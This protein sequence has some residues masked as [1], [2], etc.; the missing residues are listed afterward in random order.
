[1]KIILVAL[2]FGVGKP[3]TL[4]YGPEVHGL[5]SSKLFPL[6]ACLEP[7]NSNSG[8]HTSCTDTCQGQI[9]HHYLPEAGQYY[10]AVAYHQQNGMPAS[11]TLLHLYGKEYYTTSSALTRSTNSESGLQLTEV[12]LHIWIK[13]VTFFLVTWVTRSN[14]WKLDP[15]KMETM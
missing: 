14:E 10:I 12:N 11:L 7:W 2:H 3:P 5:H 15:V 1:M 6:F 9:K 13:W 8:S 4:E